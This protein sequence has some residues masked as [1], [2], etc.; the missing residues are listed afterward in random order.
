MSAARPSPVIRCQPHPSLCCC[1]TSLCCC[2]TRTLPPPHPGHNFLIISRQRPCSSCAP[3]MRVSISS[4]QLCL[5]EYSPDVLPC[6]CCC[7]TLLLPHSAGTGSRRKARPGAAPCGTYQPVPA[8]CAS[9]LLPSF[10]QLRLD[11]WIAIHHHHHQQQQQQQ[12][13]CAHR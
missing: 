13:Q 7:L 8:N 3:R 6:C 10:C 11:C 5:L 2:V 9:L 12:Q 4:S 1:V